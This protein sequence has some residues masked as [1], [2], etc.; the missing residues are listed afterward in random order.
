MPKKFKAR[1]PKPRKEY[2]LERRVGIKRVAEEEAKSRKGRKVGQ[3]ATP[4]SVEQVLA[5][6]ASRIN[7]ATLPEYSDEWNAQFGESVKA[8]QP[9][10][11]QPAPTK[12][13]KPDWSGRSGMP[14]EYPVGAEKYP[15]KKFELRPEKAKKQDG[16][17]FI[18]ESTIP[19]QEPMERTRAMRRD[20][21]SRTTM[22]DEGAKIQPLTGRKGADTDWVMAV[23]QRNMTNQDIINFSDQGM[24]QRAY[25]A[26]KEVRPMRLHEQEGQKGAFY[27]DSHTHQH[28]DPESGKYT[29]VPNWAKG[30][31][32]S[33]EHT[34]SYRDEV[35]R[36]STAEPTILDKEGPLFATTAG[37]YAKNIGDYHPL[38]D[39]DMSGMPIE[40][41]KLNAPTRKEKRRMK[42]D[43]QVLREE[44][45]YARNYQEPIKVAKPKRTHTHSGI[46][47]Q[48]GGYEY[49]GMPPTFDEVQEAPMN[50][51]SSR[52]SG[53]ALE[54]EPEPLSEDLVSD[55]GALSLIPMDFDDS[56]ITNAMDS[57]SITSAPEGV[58]FSQVISEDERL[59]RIA[60]M[61]KEKGESVGGGG[62]RAKMKL[63]K[64]QRRLKGA[65]DVEKIEIQ[66]EINRMFLHK[67]DSTEKAQRELVGQQE[68][69]FLPQ[70][71]SIQFRGITQGGHDITDEMGQIHSTRIREEGDE[72][73]VVG[74]AREGHQFAGYEKDEAGKI[75]EKWEFVGTYNKGGGTTGAPRESI[76]R[77]KRPSWAGRMNPTKKHKEWRPDDDEPEPEEEVR[78][79]TEAEDKLHGNY[80]EWDYDISDTEE[81]DETPEGEDV[82][83]VDDEP[84]AHNPLDTTWTESVDT[85]PT[86][87]SEMKFMGSFLPEEDEMGPHPLYEDVLAGRPM[88]ELTQG[89]VRAGER[90]TEYA[91]E[92]GF[93]FR[94]GASKPEPDP[95]GE[96][97]SGNVHIA[98]R[99]EPVQRDERLKRMDS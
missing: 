61:E 11:Y 39:M 62:V 18:K 45:E 57:M 38:P 16:E 89:E 69:T 17:S 90:W 88:R 1:K 34:E 27:P 37:V 20:Y 47:L 56:E 12:T 77:E 92:Q 28:R 74:G 40:H 73:R 82:Q 9:P 54:P 70:K 46:P 91:K 15:Q 67:R 81:E 29:H 94:A 87:R 98:D 8:I 72:M 7:P 66:Q 97:A 26:Q 80:E 31:G 68:A 52:L 41:E 3:G 19:S 83:P 14:D 63:N 65:T 75:T 43:A 58:P 99:P 44:Q 33:T 64:L 30:I 59:K 24:S 32:F 13:E 21:L 53:L 84:V 10:S 6:E 76:P 48:G 5:L 86:K 22:T 25:L 93:E 51:I 96:Y 36:K 60:R 4:Q 79:P 50:A 49:E 55:M 95:R 71:S 2:T 85:R 23:E 78:K 42:S 35:R